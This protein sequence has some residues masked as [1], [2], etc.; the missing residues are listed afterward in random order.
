MSKNKNKGGRQSAKSN[1]AKTLIERAKREV[2]SFVELY[3]KF[4]QQMDIE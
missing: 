2:P 4:E 1:S 3:Q